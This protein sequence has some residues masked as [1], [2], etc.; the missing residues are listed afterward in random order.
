MPDSSM[1]ITI[2]AASLTLFACGAAGALAFARNHDVCR[3]V[4]HGLALCGAVL[5]LVL[6]VIGLLGGSF[7][8]LL[9]SILPLAGGFVL[10]LDRLSSFLLLII[11]VGVIPSALY[12]IGYTQHYK[13][14]L[15]SMG[16]M[17]NVFVPAMMLVVLSRNVLT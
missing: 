16:F 17:L 6:S 2:L 3:W 1:L 12:A 9:P 7:Q 4:T 13:E 15:P 14:K 10:G 8:L 11:A 5:I